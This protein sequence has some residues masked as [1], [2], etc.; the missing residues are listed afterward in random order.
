LENL[1]DVYI[2]LN[3]LKQDKKISNATHNIYAYR[4]KDTDGKFHE[5]SEDDGEFGASQQLLFLLQ[6]YEIENYIVVVTRWY[7]GIHLGADRFKIINNLA[8]I[9]IEDINKKI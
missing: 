5:H 6:K 3:Q 4:V 9:L 7:G 2:I 1:Q 8:K